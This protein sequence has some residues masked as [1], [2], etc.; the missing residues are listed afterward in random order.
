MTADEAIRW[1]ETRACKGCRHADNADHA[2][3]A[4]AQEV[5]ELIRVLVEK[6]K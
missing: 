6:T 3:C 1:A 5:A 2:A 4:T